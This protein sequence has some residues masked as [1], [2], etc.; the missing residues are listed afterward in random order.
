L[1][2]RIDEAP[3]YISS[4]PAFLQPVINEPSSPFAEALRSIKMSG[5]SNGEARRAKVI[6]LTSCLPHEGKST[7]SLCIAEMIAKS[8]KRV[9]LMDFDRHSPAL[10]RTLAPRASVG[11]FDV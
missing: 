5:D 8:G 4:E 3:R 1:L 7:V 9:V 10:S 2:T 6:G 11:L